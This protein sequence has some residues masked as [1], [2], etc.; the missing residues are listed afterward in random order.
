MDENRNPQID[1]LGKKSRRCNARSTDEK[2]RALV[3]NI[4]GDEKQ[5]ECEFHPS[6]GNIQNYILSAFV[7][8][9]Q[10]PSDTSFK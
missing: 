9:L 2:V 1:R 3:R 7:H 5:L 10:M 6:S 4:K 8:F